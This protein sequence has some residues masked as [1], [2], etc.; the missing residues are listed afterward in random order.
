[1]ES[2][3]GHHIEGWQPCSDSQWEMGFP[4][5]VQGHLLP[6]VWGVQKTIPWALQ[7]AG[8][9]GSMARD[10]LNWLI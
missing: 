7:G 4:E 10:F 1:M 5:R 3:G 2:V 6:I 9:P 8:A